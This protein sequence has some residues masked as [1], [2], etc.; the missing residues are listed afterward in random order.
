MAQSAKHLFVGSVEAYSGKSTVILGILSQLAK[1]GLDLAYG[2]PLGSSAED[3]LVGMSERNLSFLADNLQL[4]PSQLR[5]PMISLQPETVIQRLEGTDS[6]DYRQQLQ[7]YVA[8]FE[9]SFVLL[10]GSRTLGEGSLFGL[11]IDEMAE[12][13]DAPILLIARYDALSL[14]ANL[15]MAKK[16]LGN[17]LI[18]VVINNIPETKLQEVE[19]LIK[20]Y[21]EEKQ[22]PVFGMVPQDRLLNSVSV[23]ELSH[24][25]NAKVLCRPD[26]LNLMIENLTIGAM[27]V[28][29][30]L[31]YFRKRTNM[32][33]VTG[34]DRTDLQMAA[35][36]TSTNCLILTGRVEPMPLILNRAEDLEIPI[37]AVDS[38]TLTTVEI[39][40]AAFGRVPIN[41]PIKI[42]RLNQIMSERV[43]FARLFTSLGLKPVLTA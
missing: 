19:T 40:D 23:R 36:E 42:K 33:V 24:R 12:S 21:L 43:D 2:K 16:S 28:N 26:R 14:A 31:E 27:N 29:S 34:S 20:P 17:R 22:I 1:R 30:A 37:L 25:L 41:E 10:E 35:L 39:V 7:D 6:Q 3:N 11:S 15:L 18:G 5:P 32:V 13:I 8:G 9:N 38:D 4:S